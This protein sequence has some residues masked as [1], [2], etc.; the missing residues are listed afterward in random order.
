ME[1]LGIEIPILATSRGLNAIAL[2]FFVS[3][4]KFAEFFANGKEAV[5]NYLTFRF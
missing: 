5:I 1:P 2:A 4:Q 3:R